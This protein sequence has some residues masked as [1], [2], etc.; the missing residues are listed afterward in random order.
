M[1]NWN[2]KQIK[3]LKTILDKYIAIIEDGYTRDFV[4][5]AFKFKKPSSIIRTKL[6][7]E[8]INNLLSK[9]RKE[10]PLLNC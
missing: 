5:K 10:I 1:I 7:L 3:I 6:T 9:M 2:R 8:E 4:L